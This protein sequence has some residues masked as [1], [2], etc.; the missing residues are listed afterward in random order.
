MNLFRRHNVRLERLFIVMN[1]TLATKPAAFR[2]GTRKNGEIELLRFLFCLVVLLFHEQ[3]YLLGEAS[4]KH[5]VHLAFFP[6]GA[7]GVEFFFVLSGAL[8]ASSILR[9]QDSTPSPTEYLGFLSRKYRS[10]FPQHLVAFVIAV[11]VWAVF[12][13]FHSAAQLI[14]YLVDS[15][16]NLLLIQMS[17]LS[18]ANP[19]H[20][21]WYISCM[22]LSMAI[23]YPICRRYYTAFTHYFAPLGALF[24]LGYLFHTTGALTG[25]SVWT[26]LCYK[27]VL[28]ALA[29]IALGTTA[30]ELSRH[31][32][33]RSLTN[34][35]RTYFTLAEAFLL[36]CA[37]C[38]SV[39]T[40]PKK[41]EFYLLGVMVLLLT[42]SFS[43]VT[44]FSRLAQNRLSY[45]LGK[46]SLPIYLSQ[47]SG[48]RLTQHFFARS[49][50]QEQLIVAFLL[51]LLLALL[52]TLLAK[53]VTSCIR[54]PQNPPQQ[55]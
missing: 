26:G 17:G 9:K 31:L 23:L 25:V 1:H 55:G 15:I 48:I 50:L 29:E 7:I 22:L 46:L 37:I 11:G 34:R 14:R 16:P 3:K 18:L 24:I 35:Q 39:M 10:I 20:V 33:A 19:N 21:E 42:I 44:W 28:R 40:F 36:F 47:I 41:Y 5:G 30:Y 43:N 52:T 54:Q 45:F 51:T 27:S 4:L 2:T 38:F 32:S 6:H 13:S 8:M 49:S 12:S 53:G